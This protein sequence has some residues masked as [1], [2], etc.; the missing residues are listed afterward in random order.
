GSTNFEPDVLLHQRPDLGGLPVRNGRA[1]RISEAAAANLQR[2][3]QKLHAYLA[4]VA[5]ADFRGKRLHPALPPEA[6]RKEKRGKR[7]EWLRVE[8]LPPLRQLLRHEDEPLRLPLVELLAEIHEPPASVALAQRAV[9]DLSPEVRAAAVRALA[10][11][12]ADDY[13]AMLL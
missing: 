1:C 3:A 12:P 10:G 13:R 6:L 11:R 2:L 4:S 7:P 5:P 9:F 8:A